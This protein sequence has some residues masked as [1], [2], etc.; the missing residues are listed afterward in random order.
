MAGEALREVIAF[1]GLGVDKREFSDLDKR[2]SGLRSGLVTLTR[3]LTAGVVVNELRKIVTETIEMGDALHNAA[4]RIGVTTDALQ[5]LRF[6]GDLAGVS[7]STMD[8]SLET[9][10]RRAA[11]A[12]R[13]TGEA[14]KEFTELGIRLRD[15]NGRL[16]S[17]DE[18]LGDVADRFANVKTDADR[19]RL[20]FGLFGREGAAMGNVLRGGSKELEAARAEA[21]ALGGVM[22]EDLVEAAVQADDA[23]DRFHQ[24]VLGFK[25][26]IAAELLPAVTQVIGGLVEW[27][28]ENRAAIGHDI[29]RALRFFV[30]LLRSVFSVVRLL[31]GAFR[32]LY[33]QLDPLQQGFLKLAVV[34]GGLALLFGLIP[35]LVVGVVAVLDDIVAFFQGRDSLLGLW[36]QWIERLVKDMTESPINPEDVWYVRTT[37]LFIKL[38]KEAIELF[39]PIIDFWAAM[40]RGDV[41][42]A[43]QKGA[44]GVW[45]MLKS[46]GPFGIAMKG[47]AS[48]AG[49]AVAGIPGFKGFSHG[50]TVVNQTINAAPGQDAEAVGNAAAKK[51]AEAVGGVMRGALRTL[52]QRSM[53]QDKF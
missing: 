26:T 48:M 28:K 13:G 42:G 34:L 50:D 1:F 24:V 36:V 3:A 29:G 45:N 37:Q 11:E 20:A 15:G 2:I 22:S 52:P 35:T 41:N 40:A 19:T 46:G 21:R 32:W 9:F 49:E 17:T 18:L 44:E 23:L 38:L 51:T 8:H 6:A 7:A 16:R 31:G 33:D 25:N 27:G 12:A 4:Q 43:I 14:Q 10:V 39:D 53:I 30:D 47:V 5:E